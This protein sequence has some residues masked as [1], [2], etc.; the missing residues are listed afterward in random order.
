MVTENEF[1]EDL[2]D[3]NLENINSYIGQILDTDPSMLNRVRTNNL[4]GGSQESV[5]HVA[6]N[7]SDSELINTILSH[8][9]S[10]DINLD[11]RDNNNSTPLN[12]AVQNGNAGITRMFIESGASPDS[13]D[14][15][16]GA[17]PLHNASWAGHSEI[18]DLL[19]TGT[20]IN[21]TDSF[22]NSTPLHYASRAGSLNSVNS[23]LESRASVNSTDDMGSTPLHSFAAS[24][25]ENR[26]VPRALI[27]NGADINATNN[28]GRTPLYLAIKFGN[29]SMIEEILTHKEAKIPEIDLD[30]INNNRMPDERISENNIETMKNLQA[31]QQLEALKT[32]GAVKDHLCTRLQ[33]QTSKQMLREGLHPENIDNLFA[34]YKNS[35]NENYPEE[36]L[37]NDFKHEIKHSNINFGK[38]KRELDKLKEAGEP[39][40]PGD[41]DNY[42]AQ[43]VGDFG[44][45]LAQI[46]YQVGREDQRMRENENLTDIAKDQPQTSSAASASAESSRIS[47]GIKASPSKRRKTQAKEKEGK[48]NNRARS[49]KS[50]VNQSSISSQ[51]YGGNEGRRL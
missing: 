41:A 43:L 17:T 3:N 1:A 33:E 38:A 48:E 13:A 35:F 49:N 21:R 28:N 25:A 8:P 24:E 6:A 27:N 15:L 19:S 51:I 45:R 2:N 23:L 34:G 14:R 4:I 44:G 31:K 46:V 22:S 47:D 36:K 29:N 16:Y 42:K 40:F 9:S 12:N 37:F 10:H 50:T 11:L 39:E 5:L 18:V 32:G 7:Y 30:E 20:N 26:E